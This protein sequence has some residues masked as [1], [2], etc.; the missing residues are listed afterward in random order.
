MLNQAGKSPHA[1]LHGMLGEAA[2]LPGLGKSGAIVRGSKAS[3]NFGH[4]V[5]S[6]LIS[7]Y[8][9]ARFKEARQQVIFLDQREHPGSRALKDA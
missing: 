6:A 2:L 8:L 7:H 4:Q 9:G 5:R 3:L 1:G